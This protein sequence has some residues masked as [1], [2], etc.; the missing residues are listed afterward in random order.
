[1]CVL[2][3]SILKSRDE[4]DVT[5]PLSQS[6]T[7]TRLFSSILPLYL[8]SLAS[9]LLPLP[10]PILP[11]FIRGRV[12]RRTTGEDARTQESERILLSPSRCDNLLAILAPEH[13]KGTLATVRPQTGPQGPV[14]GPQGPRY[15]GK[16][17]Q[18]PGGAGSGRK[19]PLA[20][21]T[22]AEDVDSEA[23]PGRGVSRPA[24]PGGVSRPHWEGGWTAAP[25]TGGLRNAGRRAVARGGSAPTSAQSRPAPS[26]AS[27][28][29]PRPSPASHP[30]TAPALSFRPA[31][32]PLGE[33]PAAAAQGPT[34]AS[35]PIAPPA[36]A[37]PG[38]KRAQL[39]AA[40]AA[41]P[42]RAE[43]A[44]SRAAAP[45]RRRWGPGGP[46]HLAAAR[47]FGSVPPIYSD[48]TRNP[49]Q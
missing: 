4:S 5:L 24:G 12:L 48:E 11:N 20:A 14:H 1:M 21:G 33:L 8:S 37:P 23:A 17:G 19:G 38:R 34:T 41:A 43:R 18:T 44:P 6:C 7:F 32:R 49:K 26:S 25:A 15:G 2:L 47:A 10:L 22:G 3:L 9:S 39:Q 27:A 30:A 13:S 40:Q 36:V 35:E 46:A 42:R 31:R 28:Y 16:S 29:R 45:R